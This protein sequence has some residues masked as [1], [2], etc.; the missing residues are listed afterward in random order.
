MTT[1]L[2]QFP[3]TIV[4]STEDFS[5]QPFSYTLLIK[6]ALK[7]DEITYIYRGV[8]NDIPCTMCPLSKDCNQG[9][10]RTKALTDYVK[11]HHPE[12]FV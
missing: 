6:T 2:G 3:L 11:K 7:K 10:D 5:P 12:L 9:I 8:C 1:T 4:Q